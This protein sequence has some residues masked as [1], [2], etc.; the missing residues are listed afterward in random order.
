MLLLISNNP[1]APRQRLANPA[2]TPPAES[3]WLADAGHLV[4]GRGRMSPAGRGW[5]ELNDIETVAPFRFRADH[6]TVLAYDPAG[7]RREAAVR[8]DQRR[9]RDRLMRAYGGKCAV[10][11]CDVPALLDAAHL[12]T[13]RID[14]NGVLLR[15]DLHRMID[16]GLAGIENGR[17]RLSRP[18]P[19][20]IA[21]AY[22]EFDGKRLARPRR[23]RSAASA[24]PR[25]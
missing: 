15:T 19:D 6:A 22:G 13:W 25:S 23:R 20:Y 16:Q 24:P 11:G 18:V 3:A 2:Q 5:I 17:F 14:S 1:L 21:T 9:F 8:P 7:P 12:R 10:T 4:L